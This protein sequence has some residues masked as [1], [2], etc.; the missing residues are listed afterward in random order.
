MI[1]ST[2]VWRPRLGRIPAVS[3]R[4]VAPPRRRVQRH[5]RWRRLAGAAITDNLT[6]LALDEGLLQ[7][8][9]AVEAIQDIAK[10][11][12]EDQA[13]VIEGTSTR[14]SAILQ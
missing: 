4:Q 12:G 2:P 7:L 13:E 8:A 11:T 6:Q 14:S 9:L 5:L 3:T 10:A 1:R